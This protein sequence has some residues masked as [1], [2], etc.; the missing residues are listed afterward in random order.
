M[1]KYQQGKER[2]R[3]KAIQF[4]YNLSMGVL[5]SWYDIAEIQAKFERAARQ[6]G[7]LKEFREN[8]II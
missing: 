8:G 5:Y 6:Y 7:L 2:A 3:E 4:Q 1:N